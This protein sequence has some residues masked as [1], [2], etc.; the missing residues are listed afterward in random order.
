LS[1]RLTGSAERCDA[2]W[3]YRSMQ[4]IMHHFTQL[5]AYAAHPFAFALVVAYG[6]A[7]AI[8]SPETFEWHGMATLVTLMIALFI[9]RSSHRDTQALHAKLDELLLS[10]PDAKAELIALDDQ[11]PEEVEHFR[12]GEKGRQRAETAPETRSTGGTAKGA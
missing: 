9:Q 5:G 4:W 1:A 11:E 6:L 8:L 3:R 2:E 12:K 7:W 10:H